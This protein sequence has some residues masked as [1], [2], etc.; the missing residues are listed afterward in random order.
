M[1]DDLPKVNVAGAVAKPLAAASQ[2]VQAAAKL[3]EKHKLSEKLS[4]VG[5]L[6]EH[7]IMAMAIAQKELLLTL[8]GLVVVFHG[9]QFKNIILCTQLVISFL[10]SRLKKSV[11]TIYDD[12][13]KVAEKAEADA[14]EPKVEE[15]EEDEGK[16]KHAKKREAKKNADKDKAS[17]LAD[18]SVHI[19]AAKKMLKSLNSERLTDS[20]KEVLLCLMAC[21]LVIHGGLAQHVAVAHALVGVVAP[22]AQ[23]FLE[24]EGFEDQEMQ[25]WTM[26]MLHFALWLVMLPL[27]MLFSTAG[28]ILNFALVGSQLVTTHGSKFAAAT[29]KIPDA[30]A[31]LSSAPG[32]IAFLGLTAFG[33]IWQVW[34]VSSGGGLYWM[35][36]LAYLPAVIVEAILGAL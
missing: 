14:P 3:A 27:S 10:F 20:T 17:A 1:P 2:G 33:F 7:P 32:I 4:K 11:S 31:F 8:V 5:D 9:A 30:E 23:K 12:L 25:P 6:K 35:L 19:E 26:L 18:P 34:T 15:K 21:L 13:T 36:W 28:L 24:F 29:K 22:L 16:S